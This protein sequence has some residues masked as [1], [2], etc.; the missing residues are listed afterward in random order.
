VLGF[1]AGNTNALKLDASAATPGNGVQVT[2]SAAGSRVLLSA[3]S[4]ATD[5]GLDIN[6]K[7][8]GT[9]RLGNASTG[10]IVLN[11]DA[12]TKKFNASYGSSSGLGATVTNTTDMTGS[13]GYDYGIIEQGTGAS[14]WYFASFKSAA[15]TDSEFLFRGDGTALCDGSWTGGGADYAEY[16]EWQDGN[17]TNEDR[18]GISVVMVDDKV[19]PATATDA[20]ADIIGIVS[21]RPTVVGDA[22][23]MRW[24]D[25][26]QRDVYGQEVYESATMLSWTD[27]EGQEYRYFSDSLP[28]GVTAPADA[29]QSTEQ[30]K[31]LNP[32]F[33][34]TLE[35]VSR[36]QRKEWVTI[37]LMGK[38]ALRAGQ[39]VGANWRKMKTLTDSVELWLVR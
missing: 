3:I 24:K 16:F 15:G 22:A 21:A 33:D 1:K 17:P 34:P 11:R 25:K 18:R 12:T 5:E 23:E 8:A 13:F 20:A 29:V 4:T 14:S 10:N 9:I 37:G 35:Y 26:Y 2:S 28:D 27:E 31:V 19:R 36:S 32:D 6:A 38:L 39:P 7:G 30:R